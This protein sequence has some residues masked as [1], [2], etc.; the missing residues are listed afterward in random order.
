MNFSTTRV[1]IYF[2]DPL[3]ETTDEYNQQYVPVLS[4]LLSELFILYF[5]KLKR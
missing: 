4:K 1:F 3:S 2:R 5:E